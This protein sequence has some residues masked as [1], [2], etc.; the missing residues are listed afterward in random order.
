[1]KAAV[2][3]AIVLGHGL[4]KLDNIFKQLIAYRSIRISIVENVG[5]SSNR[6]Q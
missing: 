1:M 2:Y 5:L 3:N 6:Q 4:S